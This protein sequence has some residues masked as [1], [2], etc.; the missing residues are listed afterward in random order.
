MSSFIVIS[1]IQIIFLYFIL[2]SNDKELAIIGG[3]FIAVCF[4]IINRAMNGKKDSQP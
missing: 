2:P 4:I 1:I 3:P